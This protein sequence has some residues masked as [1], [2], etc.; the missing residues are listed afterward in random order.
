MRVCVFSFF[1][2]HSMGVWMEESE[3]GFRRYKFI[4]EVKFDIFKVLFPKMFC[5]VFN[6]FRIKVWI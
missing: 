1:L 5:P 4:L 2:Y 3:I 6:G